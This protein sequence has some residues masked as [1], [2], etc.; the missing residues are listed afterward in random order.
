MWYDQQVTKGSGSEEGLGKSGKSGKAAK[1]VVVVVVAVD[2][3]GLG[4]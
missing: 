2:E 3:G 4:F 1:A